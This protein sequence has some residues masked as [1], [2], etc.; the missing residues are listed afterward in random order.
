MTP[1]ILPSMKPESDPTPG[2]DA[3]SNDLQLAA[4]GDKAARDRLWAEHYD[5]LRGCAKGWFERNWQRRGDQYGISLGGTDIVNVA[6]QRLHDRTAAMTKGRTWFFRCFYTECLRIAVEHYRK[7]K[8]DKGRG[9]AGRAEFE[10]QFLA[11]RRVQADVQ[12]IYDILAE[13]ERMDARVGQVAMLK[14]FETVPDEKKPGAVRGL[15]NGEV[16]ELL[17]YSLRTV[18]K[19]WAFAKSYLLDK[20]GVAK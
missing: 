7:T 5:M 11:D 17:D 4:E 19:D 20:L 18:E 8:N 1:V 13:L 15:T 6:Y 10:S 14:V 16:A 2:T 9:K 12:Q 3:F